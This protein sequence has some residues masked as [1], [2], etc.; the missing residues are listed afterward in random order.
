MRTLDV[1]ITGPVTDP[2]IAP[3][4]TA[5]PY[6]T[7]TNLTV[8]GGQIIAVATEAALGLGAALIQPQG[9]SVTLHYS[10]GAPGDYPQ[11]AF[12]PRD[13]RYTGAAAA[14]VDASR[15]IARN[16][17]GGRE[18]IAALVAEA[19]ARFAYAHPKRKFNE[20]LDA[21]PYLSCGLTEGS[22]VDINTYL[23]ASLR[24]AG[25]EAGYFYGYFFPLERGGMTDDGHCWVVTRHEGEVLEW[26][27]AHH[28]KANLGPTRAGLNPRPG[29]RVALTHSMGHCYDLPNGPV[30]LKLLGEPMLLAAGAAPAYTSLVARLS[31][32]AQTAM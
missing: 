3:T 18:G 21:V 20:G 15:A 19:E 9:G 29:E 23:V 26:D 13:N 22:C 16:A 25:Y 8:S 17:G 5:T 2:V 27:I 4:G 10:I 30:A 7:V 11:A 6:E 1:T 28:L 12:Q 31:P 24:A 32:V 14:L